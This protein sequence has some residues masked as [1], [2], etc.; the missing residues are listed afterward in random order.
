[1]SDD[2]NNSIHDS[3]LTSKQ[4]FNIQR[5]IE[6][7]QVQQDT[8]HFEL[9]KQ[10]LFEE[11]TS[12]KKQC[13][14]LTKQK[15]AIEIRSHML[16]DESRQIIEEKDN[17]LKQLQE[18]NNIL[19]SNDQ[20]NVNE[21]VKYQRM[22]NELKDENIHLKNEMFSLKTTLE[23]KEKIEKEYQEQIHRL[24]LRITEL[25]DWN[26][27]FQ[28]NESSETIEMNNKEYSNFQSNIDLLSSRNR[29]LENDLQRLQ[30]QQRNNQLALERLDE[31]EE[32]ISQLQEELN[33]LQSN[34]KKQQTGADEDLN[35]RLVEERKRYDA[36]VDLLE[37]TRLQMKNEKKQS[38]EK[39]LQIETNLNERFQQEKINL[40][41]QLQNKDKQIEIER[42]ERENLQKQINNLQQ[43]KDDQEQENHLK[44]I[45][46]REMLERQIIELNEQVQSLENDKNELNYQ[47]DELRQQTFTAT[48]GAPPMINISSQIRDVSLSPQTSSD[49]L[50]ELESQISQNEKQFRQINSIYNQFLT[51]LPC[52]YTSSNDTHISFEDRFANLFE[53]FSTYIGTFSII[54]EELDSLKQILNEREDELE[55]LRT[56]LELTTHKLTQLQEEQTLL[57]K[58]K[59]SESDEDELEEI[60][61][62]QQ[63]APSRQS[64]LSITPGEKQQLTA[65]NELLSSLLIEKEQELISLQQAKKSHEDLIKNLELLQLN[66]Q[67]MEHDKDIKQIEL[68]D[69]KN[70]LDEKLRENSSLKKEKMYF[71]EKLAELERERYEQQSIIQMSSKQS[72]HDDK[73][74]S[75]TS[76]TTKVQEQNTEKDITEEQYGNLHC[77][78]NQLLELYKRQ[79]DESVSYYNEY[80]RIFTLYNDLNTKYNQLEIDY[81]SIQS[82]IQQ[83]NEAY[84]QCQ[85]ELNNYQNLLYHQK[86]KS[87]DIDLLRSTLNE[88][89]IKLQQL[90]NNENQLLIKQTELE[91]N[92]KLLEENNIKLKSN[93][94]LFEQIQL[95]LK[96]ITHERDLAIVEKKQIENE[97]K[98]NREKLLQS[99][100]REVKLTNEVE[101]LCQIEKSLRNQL[102]Q[103]NNSNQEKVELIH[104]FTNNNEPSQQELLIELE[105]LKHEYAKIKELNINLTNQLQDQIKYSQNLQNNLDQFQQ[106]H[107]QHINEHLFQY[108]DSLREQIS[109][110][111]RLTNENNELHQHLEEYNEILLSVNRLNDEIKIKDLLINKLQIE[112]ENRNKQILEFNENFQTINDTRIEKQLVKNILLSYFHTPIDKQQEVIPILS[113][114]VGFTQEE[115]QKVMNAISNNYNNS[116]STNWLTGW[117][118]T[119]S[120]KPR[121]QSNISFDQSDKSFTE[122]LIQYVDQQSV[123]TFSQP[124]SNFNTDE[125]KNHQNLNNSSVS[126]SDNFTHYPRDTQLI[127]VSSTTSNVEQDINIDNQSSLP[128]ASINVDELLTV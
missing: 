85:N 75:S 24:Q 38:E 74:I 88:R 117:L 65:Q 19:L 108:Q 22:L 34:K 79:Q 20:P 98:F 87:D 41:N 73:G 6:L 15:Q 40:E 52:E 80:T 66:L 13:D 49:H 7:N 92:M 116:A 110:S 54:Q 37:E 58:D 48:P 29:Q 94:Q 62:I 16:L 95:D 47:I 96:R 21:F 32:T 126:T 35:R 45:Y 44:E 125:Y 63:R 100:E 114:L 103:I 23:S 8:D 82:L 113:A 101:R 61:G 71:I 33:Q 70:I 3:S 119:N 60:L 89:E 83:K 42:N 93:Q 77:N 105:T 39:I 36:I 2:T 121:I 46:V 59:S 18:T 28:K 97:I 53:Q 55:K 17:E 124:I 68:N 56:H 104:Q 9:E 50:F 91:T 111:A 122:L 57:N 31:Y 78:Y 86:K 106:E 12:L 115:Y 128:T 26:G 10:T 76:I 1:M 123:D 5:T 43:S 4:S 30:S 84:L 99:E 67:Q 64:L 109:I 72:S 69:I 51:L 127:T 27:D 112:I 120:S 14:E 11:C 25:E 107:E 81:K 102:E 118:N 90:I